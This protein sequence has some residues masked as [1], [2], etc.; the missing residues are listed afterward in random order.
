MP[1]THNPKECTQRLLPVR[2][3]LDVLS[4]KWKIPIII[5]LTFGHIRFREL[6]RK[7]EGISPKM[8]SKELKELE[9]HGL[10]S[11]TVYDTLPITVEYELTEHGRTMQPLVEQLYQWGLKHREYVMKGARRKTPR[12][13]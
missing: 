3:A 1:E 4:G 12:P 10:V 8:L 5:G 2:D 11:R 13:A 6:H 7:I 9:E